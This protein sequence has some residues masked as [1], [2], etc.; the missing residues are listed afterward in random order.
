[1]SE[2]QVEEIEE[3]IHPVEEEG[4]FYVSQISPIEAEEQTKPEG[5]E[6]EIDEETGEDIDDD[7]FTYQT[8]PSV[9]IYPKEITKMAQRILEERLKDKD[10]DASVMKKT[11]SQ[12]SF[13]IREEIKRLHLDRY[14]IIVNVTVGEK[15]EQDIMMNFLYL[16]KPECDHFAVAKYE[17]A[18]VF[19]VAMIFLIYKQ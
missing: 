4:V 2:E 6:P 16:W 18:S 12:I 5:K 15:C 13:I 7:S 17:N 8:E 10:Y 14:R 19:S 9:T 3:S 1:M 11:A